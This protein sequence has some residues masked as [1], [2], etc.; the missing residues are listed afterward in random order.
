[1]FGQ[2]LIVSSFCSNR[3]FS[4]CPLSFLPPYLP[5]LQPCHTQLWPLPQSGV[6]F[7][8][9]VKFFSMSGEFPITGHKAQNVRHVFFP[10]LLYSLAQVL[11]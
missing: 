4:K 3:Q 5:T 11:W 8:L 1:M 7:P 6:F 2:K 9:L 10:N